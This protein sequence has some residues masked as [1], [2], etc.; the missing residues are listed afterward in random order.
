MYG[1]WLNAVHGV[2][3]NI[4]NWT[5]TNFYFPTEMTIGRW[6]LAHHNSRSNWILYQTER[7]A[8]GKNQLKGDQQNHYGESS[9]CSNSTLLTHQNTYSDYT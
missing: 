4:V 9:P 6:C 1:M 2:R 3:A 7:K 8:P 5:S